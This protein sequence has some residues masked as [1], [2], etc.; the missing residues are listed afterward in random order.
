M[1][2][3]AID[4]S[5]HLTSV[6]WEVDGAIHTLTSTEGRA[7]VRLATMV[8]EA[9]GAVGGAQALECVVVGVGPGSFTA[10]RMG[11][12]FAKGL[13]RA[14]DVPAIAVPS[15]AAATANVSDADAVL[16]ILDARKG[17]LHGGLYGPRSAVLE[18]YR[19]LRR[20]DW[21]ATMVPRAMELGALVTSDLRD[22]AEL[23][24]ELDPARVRAW[25]WCGG[26]PSLLAYARLKGLEAEFAGSIEPLY[27]R[28]SD[29]EISGPRPL[30]VPV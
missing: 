2:R 13:C 7:S 1:I 21:I 16:V 6:A 3:L 18:P 4:T 5:T 27:L 12:S 23:L 9:L 25:G 19:V 15:V 14:F 29:A 28:P 22:L 30:R 11:I 26:A 20:D 24:P 8:Q 17:E 10:L